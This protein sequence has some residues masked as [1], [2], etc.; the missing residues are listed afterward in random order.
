[1]CSMSNWR[2]PINLRFAFFLA[3]VLT[4]TPSVRAQNSGSFSLPLNA[5]SLIGMRVEDTDGQKIGTVHNLILDAR[6]GQLKYVVIGSGGILGVRATLKL[7]P[8]EVMTAATTKRQTLAINATTGQWNRA[9]VF[10]ASNLASLAQPAEAQEISRSFQPSFSRV[11]HSLSV[12]G[13]DTGHPANP[14][15]GAELKFAS[16]LIGRRVVNQN[17]ENLG[18]VADLLVGFGE[19][20]PAFAIVSTSRLFHRGHQFA[21]P[22]RTL[23]AT[24]HKLMLNASAAALAQAPAFDQHVWDASVTN[25]AERVYSYSK[26]ID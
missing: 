23:N 7:A 10:K 17:Q 2:I 24:N 25:E 12:T 21:V 9:P 22:L 8:A 5:D 19:P 16:D 6:S 18:E 13:K 26:V 4:G 1:M 3:L 20:R 14:A 15:P 11:G